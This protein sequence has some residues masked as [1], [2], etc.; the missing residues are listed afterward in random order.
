MNMKNYYNIWY[1]VR[2]VVSMF[3][4]SETQFEITVIDKIACKAHL[5]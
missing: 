3:E 1:S 2:K 4:L 5:E